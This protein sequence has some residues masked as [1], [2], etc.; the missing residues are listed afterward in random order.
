MVLEV[1]DFPNRN[2][3]RT[4][5]DIGVRGFSKLIARTN[6]KTKL[7]ITANVLLDSKE[8]YKRTEV[9]YFHATVDHT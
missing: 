9:I 8:W 5:S 4:N 1:A 7:E 2:G 6:S 3:T